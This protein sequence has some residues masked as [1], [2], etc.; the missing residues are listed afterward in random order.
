MDKRLLTRAPFGADQEPLAAKAVQA[1]APAW[2]VSIALGGDFTAGPPRRQGRWG[3]RLPLLNLADQVGDVQLPGP[4]SLP[5][6]GLGPY[7]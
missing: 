1:G 3:F 4:I 7:T 2:A 6:Q 5:G